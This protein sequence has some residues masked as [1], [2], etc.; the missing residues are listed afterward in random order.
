[1]LILWIPIDLPSRPGIGGSTT[2]PIADRIAIFLETVPLLLS[3][4]KVK[5]ISLASHSAGT[6]YALNLISRY[7]EL[8]NPTNPNITLFSPWVHQSHTSVSFLTL[9]S[10]FPNGILNHWHSV[11]EFCVRRAAP[12]FEASSVSFLP[13]S[14]IFTNAMVRKDKQDEEERRCL[15]GYGISLEVREAN[16]KLTFKRIFSEDTKGVNDEARLCLKSVKGTNWHACED[17][18]EYVRELGSEWQGR[19]A[20]GASKLRVDIVFPETDILVGEKGMQYFE[21][22]WECEASGPGI[23]VNSVKV[24]GAD[25]ESSAHPANEAITKMFERAKGA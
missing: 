18:K 2:V 9:A 4:L 6:I 11:L 1:M 10:M 3:H 24:K 12:A 8:L 17:Y 15:Q 13:L 23:E 16:T 22:C 14:S 25:H 21:D 19:V 20:E 7:P 5:H